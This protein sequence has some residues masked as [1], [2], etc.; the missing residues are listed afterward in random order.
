MSDQQS[1]F[2]TRNQG[3]T[4]RNP[5]TGCTVQLG[6]ELK[7]TGFEHTERCKCIKPGTDEE[8]KLLSD[9]IKRALETKTLEM[10]KASMAFAQLLLGMGI[11]GIP[12]AVTF[13]PGK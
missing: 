12:I 1:S 13:S 11:D 9:G 3:P 5:D 7:P 10:D 2:P 8:W 6:A 4:V